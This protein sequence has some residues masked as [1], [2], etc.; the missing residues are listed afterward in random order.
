MN[1][2]GYF[3][4]SPLLAI[5]VSG[6]ADSVALLLLADVWARTHGGQV[7][8]LTVDHGLRIGSS[9]EAQWVADTLGRR[10]IEHH[11]L[12]WQGTKPVS[13]IQ[14][15]ARNA[16]RTLLLDWCRD[17]GVLHLCLAHHAND[18]IETYLMRMARMSV[19]GGGGAVGLAGMSQ[20]REYTHARIVRPLLSFG[21][22]RL[23]ATLRSLGQDWLCDPSN[24]KEQFER[25]RVRS[26]VSELAADD[27]GVSAM[28][29]AVV[30]QGRTRR[31]LEE[32]GARTLASCAALYPA[33]YARFDPRTL[34]ANGDVAARYALSRLIM[35]IGGRRYPV[36]REKLERARQSLSP[37]S[38][39]GVKNRLTVGDC[40]ISKTDNGVLI[41]RE[42]RNLPF[43]QAVPG[44]R[45]LH[46]DS[47]FRVSFGTDDSVS[48]LP[49]EIGALGR[50]GWDQLVQAR[51]DL[52]QHAVPLSARYSL[53]TLFHDDE[54]VAVSH[55]TSRFPESHPYC[56]GFEK[57][58]FL[59]PEPVLGGMFTVAFTGFCT[60]SDTQNA[61]GNVTVATDERK[62]A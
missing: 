11:I 52:R 13:G 61:P 14:E 6:G 34:H 44:R 9:A 12:P 2:I 39:G 17:H 10:G 57:A 29:E 23:E 16:R 31:D 59:P 55:L 33:G 19:P 30:E 58:A 46:W 24:D 26:A 15:K 40:L 7:V 21:K 1:A 36:A 53:P 32:L 54:I 49:T 62:D 4:K 50:R 60:I 8:G 42:E 48:E 5:G 18:Q 37:L 43:R 38:R 25:V 35:A 51:P 28:A 41:T 56:R 20:V 3:E 45:W 22:D 47:R 27:R